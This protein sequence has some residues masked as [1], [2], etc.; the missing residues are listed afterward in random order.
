MENNHNDAIS[1]LL[2]SMEA[3]NR[4][5]NE[6]SELNF[7]KPAKRKSNT[8][9]KGSEDHKYIMSL[10]H[11]TCCKKST[12]MDLFADFGDGPRFHPYDIITVSARSFGGLSKANTDKNTLKS[13]TK[14]N[15]S[16]FTSTIGLWIFN[17]AFIEPMS[18]VLGYINEP[19][20]SEV[21]NSIN[22]KISYAILEDKIS[23][24]NLK[25]FVIQTQLL[26]GCCSAIAPSHTETIFSMEEQIAKKKQQLLSQK[27][28]KEGIANNDLTVMKDM[29]DEL[30]NYAK[31]ILKDD[32]AIDMFNSGARASWGNN[33]KNMYLMRSGIKQTDGTYSIV[34]SSYI[35]GMDPKDFAAIN[36]AAVGGPFSRS[37]KTQEGGYLERL[38][39]LSTAHIKVLGKNSDCGTDKYITVKLTKKNIGDWYFS[40]IIDGSNLVELTP[41]IADKYI[42]KEVK[43]RYSSLCKSKNGCI[44]EHCAGSLFRRIGISNIGMSS[45][46]LMS[47]LKNRAMKS[48]HDGSVNLSHVIPEKI[49]NL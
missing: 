11:Y 22:K 47:S 4:I 33:F 49:F 19:V 39:L 5:I 34:T 37:R 3:Y 27:K 14:T 24:E 44:C 46:I 20:T 40:Y 13:S 23:L 21:Y 42:D 1:S 41:E 38:F 12:I 15:S 48:F 32:P 7:A 26:M 9:E 29:E 6:A 16:E 8:I 30:I 28:Y 25:D 35:E 18:D 10:D 43:M 45:S 31:E 17:K 36:D 2:Y